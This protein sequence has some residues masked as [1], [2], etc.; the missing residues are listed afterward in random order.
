MSAIL[1]W[2]GFNADVFKDLFRK[3]FKNYVMTH[4]FDRPMVGE[5]HI[6]DWMDFVTHGERNNAPK[7]GGLTGS[8]RSANLPLS[9]QVFSDQVVNR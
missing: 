9:Y 4:P 5:L 2:D 7:P 3:Q 1:E 6:N 8:I